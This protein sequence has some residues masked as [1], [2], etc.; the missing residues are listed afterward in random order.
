M[1]SRLKHVK[2][3]LRSGEVFDAAARE[4][5]R[6]FLRSLA[7]AVSQGSSAISVAWLGWKL[8]INLKEFRY[9]YSWPLFI[10]K[11]MQNCKHQ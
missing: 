2:G 9:F 8:E 1:I 7:A 5:L 10:R 4:F 11:Q 3:P 6:V